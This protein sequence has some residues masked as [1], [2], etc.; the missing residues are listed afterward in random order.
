MGFPLFVKGKNAS[1]CNYQEMY[2]YIYA[3]KKIYQITIRTNN[4]KGTD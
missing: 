2:K 1:T 4:I 3:N